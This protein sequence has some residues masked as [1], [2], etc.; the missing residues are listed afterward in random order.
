MKKASRLFPYLL[1]FAA[2]ILLLL[3]QIVS[4]STI[5]GIDSVFHMNRFYDTAMQM[6]L[7]GII[8]FYL[9]LAFSN[10]Q[11]WLIHSMA[12]YQHTLMVCYY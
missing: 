11:E 3:P 12:H 8:I 7:A 9:C 5:V 4:K 2:A 1:I 10:Q 6:K